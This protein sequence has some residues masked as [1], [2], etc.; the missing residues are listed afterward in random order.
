MHVMD[1]TSWGAASPTLQE[2]IAAFLA[3]QKTLEDVV[4]MGIASRRSIERVV[5][6]D[7]YTHDVVLRY[8]DGVYL[9][10]DT[11]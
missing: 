7:E 2:S 1:V 5:I 11:T 9:V 10:Y 4:K 8:G 3:P 6:Q